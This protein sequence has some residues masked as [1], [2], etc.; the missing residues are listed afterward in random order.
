MASSAIGL[1]DEARGADTRCVLMPA[2]VNIQMLGSAQSGHASW[3][4]FVDSFRRTAEEQI[5]MLPAVGLFV[6]LL[7][8]AIINWQ[9]AKRMSRMSRTASRKPS[10]EDKG[11]V[12]QS[13]L[14]EDADSLV[15]DDGD[16]RRAA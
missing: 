7:A 12:E 16:H 5:D 1:S 15:D 11:G 10:H 13:A 3:S 6:L 4:Q 2:V 8:M 9:I 14:V